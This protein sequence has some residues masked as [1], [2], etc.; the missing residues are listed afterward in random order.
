VYASG[1]LISSSIYK[2]LAENPAKISIYKEMLSLGGS[3]S[4]VELLQKLDLNIEERI[5]WEQ[6]FEL[7][8]KR[9]GDVEK[10]WEEV[11]SLG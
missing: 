6:G 2:V 1:L 9:I 7:F 11:R 3:I 4:P 5:F 8:K 10:Q